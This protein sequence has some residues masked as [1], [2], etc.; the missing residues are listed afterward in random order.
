MK[1]VGPILIAL[2]AMAAILVAEGIFLNIFLGLRVAKEEAA[3][4]LNVIKAINIVE[5]IKRGLPNA[6]YYSFS[7]GAY[8]VLKTGGYRSTEGLQM[9]DSIPVWKSGTETYFPDYSTGITSNVNY[10]FDQYI[11]SSR[12]VKIPQGEITINFVED[13]ASL[14]F[15]SSGLLYNE[16]ATA[17][18]YDNPNATIQIKTNIGKMFNLGKQIV[19]SACEGSKSYTQDVLSVSIEKNN[20]AALV[21]IEDQ[22]NTFPVYDNGLSYRKMVLQF[23][24]KTCGCYGESE[25][26][27]NADCFWCSVPAPS[28]HGCLDKSEAWKC[29]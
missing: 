28:I 23:Y 3:R 22:D 12:E 27:S 20:N 11:Q 21:K 4:E 2:V 14:E 5:A 25:C 24:V 7:Q 8:E 13:K 17:K 15:S 10:I 19:D 26:K 6:L 18:I 16:S 9:I 29:V 1:G